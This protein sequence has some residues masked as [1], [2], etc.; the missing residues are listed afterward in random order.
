MR[1]SRSYGKM[2]S[3]PCVVAVDGEGDALRRGTPGRLPAGAGAVRRA[4]R[5]AGPRRA[6]RQCGRGWPGRVEH[7]VVRGRPGDSWRRARRTARAT[8]RTRRKRPFCRWRR[9]SADRNVDNGAAPQQTAGSSC[10]DACGRRARETPECRRL[11]ACIRRRS[12]RASRSPVDRQAREYGRIRPH[13]FAKRQMCL[14]RMTL[15][16]DFSPRFA[17]QSRQH[18]CSEAY[19]DQRS[20]DAYRPTRRRRHSS[21]RSKKSAG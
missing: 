16:Q 1:G 4:R 9:Y 12:R 10:V 17:R 14:A 19:R 18:S 7:L 20:Q 13:N 2:R 15:R 5:R 3:V 11:T 21:G 6:P 8:T